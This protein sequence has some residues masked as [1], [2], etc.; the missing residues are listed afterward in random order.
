MMRW[1]LLLGLSVVR[2]ALAG[3]VLDVN[4]EQRGGH[5]IAEVDMRLTGDAETLR[6]LVTDYAH[7][8]RLS[9]AILSSKVLARQDA[10]HARVYMKLHPCLTFFCKTLEQVQDVERMANGDVVAHMVPEQS[11]FDFG[12]S[13]WQFWPEPGSVV[14]RFTTELAPALWVPPV[15][16]P[17]LVQ[18]ALYRETLKTAATLDRLLAERAASRAL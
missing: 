1:M 18:Q 2:L 10:A 8:D 14:M 6:R 11:D 15:I 17:W 3:D 13:R 4:V 7:L 16:G 9:E 5:Y 12:Y